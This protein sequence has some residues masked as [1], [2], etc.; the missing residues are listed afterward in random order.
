MEPQR[1]AAHQ[2]V[3]LRIADDLRIKIEAGELKS[4][5]SLPTLHELARDYT[6]SVT[7]ARAAMGL[8]KQQGLVV[9][10]RGKALTVRARATRVERS[11][12]RHQVE[13]DLAQ[14]SEEARRRRGL[15]EDDMGGSLDSFDL[16]ARYSVV[17]ADADLADAFRVQEGTTLLRRE[18]TH[19]DKRTG[20]LAAWSI[21]WLSQ[22]LAAGNPAISDPANAAWPG[23]TMHQLYT[24]GVEVDQVIDHVTAAMPTTVEAQAWSLPEGTPLIWVRRISV[25]TTDRVVEVTDAQYPADRTMLTFVTP[26]TRWDDAR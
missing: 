3:A 4:G 17:P 2:P 12:T 15:A 24:L 21:S 8:L 5:D 18:Y 22:D 7:S 25:D 13:K 19:R 1:T 23:G 16:E 14:Q 11:S 9:G 6:C 26:L 10:G 20:A